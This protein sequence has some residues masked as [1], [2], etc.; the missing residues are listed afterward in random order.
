MV[1]YEEAEESERAELALP[2]PENLEDA[3]GA[4]GI[5]DESSTENASLVV[6]SATGAMAAADPTT[7][8]LGVKL[9]AIMNLNS[10][11]DRD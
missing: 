2:E 1:E 9:N 10:N 6:V 5:V 4:K 8:C 11:P 3:A 7:T